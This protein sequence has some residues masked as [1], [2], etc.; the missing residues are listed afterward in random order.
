MIAFAYAGQV[1]VQD[2]TMEIGLDGGLKVFTNSKKRSV[3]M[4]ASR[5]NLI[6]A[7]AWAPE[8]RLT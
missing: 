4:A 6:H 1:Y 3:G 2:I 5:I 8:V 7:I